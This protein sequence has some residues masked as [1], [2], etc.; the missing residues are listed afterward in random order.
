MN[1][2]ATQFGHRGAIP[3]LTVAQVERDQV[4][5]ELVIGYKLPWSEDTI[6]D[7]SHIRFAVALR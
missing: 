2:A 7:K 5:S 4:T 6:A 1:G 3:L